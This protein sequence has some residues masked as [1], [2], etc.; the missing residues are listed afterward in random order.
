MSD[1]VRVC[2]A[3]S[4]TGI[5]HVGSVRAA[6]FK[7]LF[8]RHHGGSFIVR[9]EDTNVARR[10]NGAEVAILDSLR[11]LGLDWDE[12]PE[13]GDDVYGTRSTILNRQFVHA[14]YLGFRL[15]SSGEYVEFSSKL[16][17]DLEEA[18]DHVTT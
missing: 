17:A 16:P 2:F 5:S 6:L 14:C 4:H 3:P 1:P 8:A 12:G 13:V 10:V 11:W 9:I 7:W 18:L 15:P